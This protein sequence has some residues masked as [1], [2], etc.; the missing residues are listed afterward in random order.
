MSSRGDALRQA[1]RQLPCV[2]SARVVDGGVDPSIDD[3][4]IEPLGAPE[5]H[6]FVLRMVGIANGFKIVGIAC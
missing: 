3:V 6:T 5:T 1:G 4:R 2:R